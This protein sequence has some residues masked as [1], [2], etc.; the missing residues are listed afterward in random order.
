MADKNILD[1]KEHYKS[2]LTIK[3]DKA[4]K[5]SNFLQLFSDLIVKYTNQIE[6]EYIKNNRGID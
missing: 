5:A 1:Y 3:S 2:I 4:E 6:E